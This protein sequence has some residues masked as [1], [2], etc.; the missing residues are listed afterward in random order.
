MNEV[1]VIFTYDIITQSWQ[2]SVKGLDTKTEARQAF[3]AVVI[4]CQR[5]EEDLLVHTL[6]DD[7]FQIVPAVRRIKP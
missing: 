5:L 1:Q 7:D 2:P 6:V 3:S 4:S